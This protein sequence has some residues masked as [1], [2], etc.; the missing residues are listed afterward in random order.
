MYKNRFFGL[1]FFFFPSPFHMSHGLFSC[2]IQFDLMALV[3]KT[4]TSDV[5]HGP[6]TQKGDTR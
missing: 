1:F 4:E 5:Q 3:G 6:A 2:L